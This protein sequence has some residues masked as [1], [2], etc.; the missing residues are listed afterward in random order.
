MLTGEDTTIKMVEGDYG[1][2]LPIELSLE[3]TEQEI[4]SSDKFSIKIFK[5]INSTPIV[6]QEY[7]NISNNTIEFKLTKE[8]SEKLKVGKYKYDID[9]YQD[10]T[11]LS[12]LLAKKLLIVEEKAGAVNESSN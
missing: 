10:N 3:S 9:W 5:D 2:V 1:I 7:S 8:E 11:F 4:T 12:N 6:S